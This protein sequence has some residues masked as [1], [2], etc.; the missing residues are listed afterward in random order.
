[1]ELCWESQG[2]R[3]RLAGHVSGVQIEHKMLSI[4][5]PMCARAVSVNEACKYRTVIPSPEDET[6]ATPY[7]KHA[8]FQVHHNHNGNMQYFRG[9]IRY[10]GFAEGFLWGCEKLCVLRSSLYGS[11][12][13]VGSTIPLLLRLHSVRDPGRQDFLN[14]RLKP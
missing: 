5:I 7:V 9:G 6:S 4:E 10:L 1:M 2:T 13:I 8:P 14:R 11:Q 12:Y 3:N